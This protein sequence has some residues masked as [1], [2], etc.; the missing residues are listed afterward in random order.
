VAIATYLMDIGAD[1][2][3][4]GEAA[5][6]A[7]GGTAHENRSGQ[8]LY[9]S[10]CSLCHGPDGQGVASTMPAL[11]GNATL[12]QPDGVNLIEV[13][14]HGIEPLRMSLTQGYGPMP[15]FRDRLSVAQMAD[16]AN[17]V[18]SVFAV[19]GSD[20]PQLSEADVNRI[21]R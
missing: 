19:N 2:P 14:A 16:L 6:A 13:I 5:V 17:Y 20:L 12:A 11:V 7:L 21:L 18:R 4:K 3:S 9:H 15:A 8:A 1:A 10:N